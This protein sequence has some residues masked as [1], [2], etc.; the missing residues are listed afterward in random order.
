MSNSP[1]G[2]HMFIHTTLFS[3][4]EYNEQVGHLWMSYIEYDVL[5]YD[6]M[7]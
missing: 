1:V 6:N 2:I 4:L 5:L 3:G 7:S